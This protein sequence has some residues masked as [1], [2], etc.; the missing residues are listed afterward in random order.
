MYS[1]FH[2]KSLEWIRPK[3]ICMFFPITILFKIRI[4]LKFT[5]TSYRTIASFPKN[6]SFQTI[7][8]YITNL[9]MYHYPRKCVWKDPY[10]QFPPLVVLSHIIAVDYL[11]L[12]VN[13]PL[14]CVNMVR[15]IVL[16]N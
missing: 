5:N 13:R 15:Y 2:R 4:W 3:H 11:I 10:M 12:S 7:Q 9:I 6:Y 8:M 1:P 14:F 16:V